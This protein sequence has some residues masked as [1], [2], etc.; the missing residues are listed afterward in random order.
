MPAVSSA[1]PAPV[2]AEPKNTGCTCPVP[3]QLG[4]LAADPLCGHRPVGEVC[5]QQQVV[6]RRRAGPAAGGDGGRRRGPYGANARSGAERRASSPSAR[7]SRPSVAAIASSTPL[8]VGAEAVDLVD[9][10]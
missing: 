4:Q 5:G 8:V 3:G 9:E 10:V 7:T 6:V 2:I 1:T